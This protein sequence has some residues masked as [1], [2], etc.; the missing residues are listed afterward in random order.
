MI[1][2]VVAMG[3]GRFA[4]TPQLPHMI[5]EGQITLTQA[6][7]LAAANFLGYLLGAIETISAKRNLILRLNCG[8][9]GSGVILALSALI[10]IS[11]AGIYVNLLLRFA[12]G[13]ASAWTLVLISTWVQEQLGKEH[14][15]RTLAFS[16]PGVGIM[17]TGI[18]AIGLDYYHASAA[19]NWLIFGI[20]ALIASVIIRH[21]LPSSLPEVST[22]TRFPLTSNAYRLII[23]YTLCGFGYILPA[24]FLSTLAVHQFPGSLLADAF[25][26]IFGFAA[27]AGMALLAVQNNIR[28]PQRLLA[29]IFCIQGL[30]VLACTLMPGLAGLLIGAVFVGSSFMAILQ[31]TM[32]L[33][34]EIAPQHLR[35]MTG[36]LTTGFSVGQLTGPLVS[37][38]STH[39]WSSMTPALLIAAFGSFLAAFLAYSI[40][41]TALH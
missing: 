39:L 34:A 33:G 30:G 22:D 15:L 3:M 12:A 23:S 25:W 9:W 19:F 31:L 18:M 35:A 40:R 1:C 27:V 28:N 13:I 10:P 29:G 36:V 7:L 6:S 2:M 16:G 41:R 24:T 32:R 4:L 21:N 5:A 38:L 37:A 26:P 11:P 17:L 20:V 14:A 8:L